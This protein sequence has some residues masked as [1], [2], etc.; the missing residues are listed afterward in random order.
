MPCGTPKPTPVLAPQPPPPQRTGP[1]PGTGGEGAPKPYACGAPRLRRSNRPAAPRQI[2]TGYSVNGSFAE[3]APADPAYVGHLL[4]SP[5]NAAPPLRDRK[6]ADS[7]VEGDGFEP[8]WGISCQVVFLFCWRFL[9]RSGKAVLRPV[10]CDQV[11]GA[12]GTGQGTETLAKLGGLPLSGACVS[13]PLRP[14]HA[15]G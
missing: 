6:F 2:N 12:R 5:H 8:V 4:P 14:E 7:S 13:Q 10:A 11:R 9:V 1:V 15:E 3:Y